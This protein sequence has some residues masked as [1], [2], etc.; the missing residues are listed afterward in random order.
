MNCRQPIVDH[1]NFSSVVI[2]DFNIV[3][4]AI[5]KAETYTP[6][7]VNAGAPLSSAIVN[8]CF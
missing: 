1:V 8:Q 2:D 6:L 7:F 4:I 5:F 3:S